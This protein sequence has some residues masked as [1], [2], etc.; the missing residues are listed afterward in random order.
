MKTWYPTR[1]GLNAYLSYTD[2]MHTSHT[3]VETS[4]LLLKLVNSLA[5]QEPQSKFKNESNKKSKIP[6]LHLKSTLQ[7]V[8]KRR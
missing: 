4:P 2:L 7:Q 6:S 1:A 8:C 5:A 3:Q